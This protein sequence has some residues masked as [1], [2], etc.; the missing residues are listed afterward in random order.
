MMKSSR[1]IKTKSRLGSK[2]V[3]AVTISD[4]KTC[5]YLFFANCLESWSITFNFCLTKETIKTLIGTLRY[6][7]DHILK[8]HLQ[9]NLFEDRFSQYQLM[10]R[11]RFLVSLYKILNSESISTIS[12]LLKKREYL[13]EKMPILMNFICWKFYKAIDLKF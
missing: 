9:N 5:I 13:Q 11:S 8:S 4:Y 12:P 7:Y 1:I 2:Y 3:S 6:Y 10:S